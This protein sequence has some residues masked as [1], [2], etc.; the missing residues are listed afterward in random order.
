M[1]VAVV[2][3]LVSPIQIDK[4]ARR[5]CIRGGLIGAIAQKLKVLF[6]EHQDDCL[7]E[8]RLQG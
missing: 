5:K 3:R 1:I 7:T 6:V 4:R 2:E 8:L